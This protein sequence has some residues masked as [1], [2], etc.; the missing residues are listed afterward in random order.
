P[1]HL[2]PLSLHDALPISTPCGLL[3][4]L[5]YQKCGLYL[6]YRVSQLTGEPTKKWS[7]TCPNLRNVELNI[8]VLNLWLV[9]QLRAY[10]RQPIGGSVEKSVSLLFVFLLCPFHPSTLFLR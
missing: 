2:L 7:W 8:F 3:R 10:E 6:I 1:P 9:H 5:P 4:Q